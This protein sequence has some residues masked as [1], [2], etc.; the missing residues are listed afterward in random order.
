MIGREPGVIE[1][2][3]QPTAGCVTSGARGWKSCRDMV[4]IRRTAIVFRMASVAVGWQSR[5]VVVHVA[6]GAGHSRVRTSKRKTGVVVIE[7]RLC[8]GCRVVAHVALPRKSDRS[9]VRIIGV[10]VIREMARNAGRIRLF[11]SIIAAV[12]LAALQ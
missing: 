12:A 8:P 11:V 10:R 3:P 4:R 1:G 9:V 6:T 5:V 7:G 2:R